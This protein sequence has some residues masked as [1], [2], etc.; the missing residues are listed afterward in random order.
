[1][2]TSIQATADGSTWFGSDQG[3]IRLKA[4][5]RRVYTERDGLPSRNVRSL[6]ADP[7]DGLW[8]AT[9][10][11]I[12]RFSNERFSEPPIRPDT[13]VGRI[14]SMAVDSRGTVWISDYHRGLLRWSQ[15]TLTSS[16]Q[17][18]DFIGST[19]SLF[20]AHDDRIWIG[21]LGGSLGVLDEEERLF[22]YDDLGITG[23][24]SAIAED[25]TGVLWIGGADGIAR[26][27]DGTSVAATS[28][29]NGFPGG[30][31]VSIV[32][33]EPGALWIGTSTGIVRIE[34]EEF[35]SIASDSHHRV[36]YRILNDADGL[37]GM[38]MHLADPSAARTVD[39][40]LWFL[41]DGGAALVDPDASP[42]TLRPP[43]VLIEE[44]RIDGQRVAPLEPLTFPA[45]SSRLE[46]DFTA[47]SFASPHLLQF[48]Y[49][50]DGFDSDWQDA[51]S[52]RQ[53]TYTNLPP[54]DFHFEV[55]AV[56][57]E[58]R[59]DPTDAS[60]AFRIAPTFYQTSWFLVVL[61]PQFSWT[62]IKGGSDVQGGRGNGSVEAGEGNWV[63]ADGGSPKG[64]RSPRRQR[65]G[66]GGRLGAWAAV[67]RE[68]E[69][70]RGAAAVARRVTRRGLAY[71][72]GGGLSPGGVEGMGAGRS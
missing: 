59:S 68:P 8:V 29:L 50:L 2:A 16:E 62:R 22:V 53:A 3:L 27:D 41:T 26:F 47:P 19:M 24:I 72:R 35:D 32:A 65:G 4:G 34:R 15:E 60:L 51:G 56:D 25:P 13:R 61:R 58:G 20:R 18:Q 45:Q 70:G 12:V 57:R 69:A 11:G 9:D 38:P 37:D 30:G 55:M 1:M 28:G 48:R 5:Q 33:D 52:R 44:I 64:D 46:I 43:R 67:E 40:E 54:G 17:L 10:G 39:N 31:V 42:E 71:S 6:A 66:W 14:T 49:R 63:G 7:R 21:F 23:D 36:R